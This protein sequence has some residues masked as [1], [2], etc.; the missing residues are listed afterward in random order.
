MMIGTVF[1]QYSRYR[2]DHELAHSEE[3]LFIA[4]LAQSTGKK[5]R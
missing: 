4:L 5:R 2:L 1:N 3:I